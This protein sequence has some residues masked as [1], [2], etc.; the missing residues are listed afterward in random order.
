MHFIGTHADCVLRPIGYECVLVT[1]TQLAI[2]H[3]SKALTIIHKHTHTHAYTQ[4]IFIHPSHIIC[5]APTQTHKH[6]AICTYTQKYAHTHTCMQLSTQKCT[7]THTHTLTQT[8]THSH[9][10]T[11]NHLPPLWVQLL[12]GLSD[13]QHVRVRR[14]CTL[15]GS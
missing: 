7:N 8:H 11:C 4:H 6:A 14:V 3:H 12:Y 1:R 15:S 13:I 5:T 10:L 9:K 2:T